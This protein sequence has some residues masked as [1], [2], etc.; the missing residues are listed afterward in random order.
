MTKQHTVLLDLNDFDTADMSEWFVNR[1]KR[2]NTYD[3]K[4]RYKLF[5]G[6]CFENPHEKVACCDKGC[7]YISYEGLLDH[8][9]KLHLLYKRFN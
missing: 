9:S 7:D 4:H 5:I 3:K 1:I 8:I 2:D 6:G